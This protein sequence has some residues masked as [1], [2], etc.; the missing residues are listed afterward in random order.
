MRSILKNFLLLVFVGTSFC[1][2]SQGLNWCPQGASWKYDYRGP[3]NQKGYISVDYVNDTVVLGKTCQVLQRTRFS[4][5]G[6]GSPLMVKYLGKTLTYYEN[7]V[8]YVW[9]DYNEDFDTLFYFTS[10]AGDRYPVAIAPLFS[11]ALQ[12]RADVQGRLFLKSPHNESIGAAEVQYDV[13]LQN[14]SIVSRIDTLADGI[15]II[16]GYFFPV[17]LYMDLLHQS[18]GGHF[19]C[20]SVN[21]QLIY[22][23]PGSPSCDYINVSPSTSSPPSIQLF[24]QPVSDQFFI[25]GLCGNEDRELEAFLTDGSGQ[26]LSQLTLT[27]GLGK[28]PASVKSGVYFLHLLK[29]GSSPWVLKM[30]VVK[31]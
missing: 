17:S 8:V 25:K 14:G 30:L 28:L 29:D 4:V 10:H 5:P 21:D 26:I 31:P 9:D 15:G 3:Q 13:R 24:P 2:T 18:E 22:Q 16:S 19:R 6:E 11:Q 1:A 27:G 7:K 20:Y 23:R 12:M